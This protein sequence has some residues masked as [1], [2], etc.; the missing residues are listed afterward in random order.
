MSTPDSKARF[1]RRLSI[2]L[3]ALSAFLLIVVIGQATINSAA[4][5]TAPA[6]QASETTDAA[7]SAY[8][9]SPVV[10]RDADDPMAIGSI[11]APVVLTEW[12]DLRCPFCASFSRDTLPAIVEEYV[13]EGLVRIEIH[14]VSFFGEQSEDAAV[15]ARAA[16]EQGRYI[17]YLTAVYDAAPDRS[18]P[19]MPRETLIAF[20]ETAGVPDSA[21]FTADLDDPALRAAV[22]Q[23]TTTAQQLGVTA[24]PF[25][26]A[27]DTALSGAQPASVFREFLDQAVEQAG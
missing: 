22:Q 1:Y 5:E 17:E 23:S 8:T 16:G 4:P 9:D 15:A 2:G 20:A 3:G 14:D 25:F 10:R 19:D 11:D 6:P 12:T 26:V 24:V 18:H 21:K 27:G 13:D 7:A